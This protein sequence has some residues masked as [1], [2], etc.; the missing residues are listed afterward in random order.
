[1]I[2]HRF[3]CIYIHISKCAGSTIEKSFGIDIADISQENNKNLF[4]WN[5]KHKI[6][7]QHATPFELLDKGFLNSKIWESY[8]KFII[9]RNPWERALSD[10]IWLSNEQNIQDKFE[11]FILGKGVFSKCMKDSN[12]KLYRG[13]HLTSQ[14]N[15]F[16]LN[17]HKIKYDRIIR[18]ENLREGLSEV[19]ND[20]GLPDSFFS[21]KINVGE[22]RFSHYSKFYDNRRKDLV[23][24][25]YY[26]D[27]KFLNYYFED[28]RTIFDF[29]NFIRSSKYLIQR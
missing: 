15:Y 18:F 11:N 26:K 14:V 22:K 17:K 21:E 27:A 2:S 1:M 10:Y 16:F 12:S 5:E 7:L 25:T 23:Y 13:D 3:K 6:F 29:A 19:K 9:V 24:N 20:L 4:G 8:Y 28:Y